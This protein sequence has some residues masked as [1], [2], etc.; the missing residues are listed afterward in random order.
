[1]KRKGAQRN[2]RLMALRINLG[3][4]P[5]TLALRAGVSPGTIRAAEH[6]KVPNVRSQYAIATALGVLPLDLW[7]LE[8]QLVAA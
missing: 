2:L 6:G 7:P 5:A 4:S 8:R 3:L 1:M